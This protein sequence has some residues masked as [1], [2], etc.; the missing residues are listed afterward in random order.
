M[1]IQGSF[2]TG[3]VTKVL[4]L[5]YMRAG[6]TFLGEMLSQQQNAFLWFE[7]LDGV[8]GHLYSLLP[9]TKPI[10]MLLK[11]DFTPRYITFYVTVG[12]RPVAREKGYNNALKVINKV[13]IDKTN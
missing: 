8:F 10:D 1:K 11:N 13:L 12:N 7:P 3:Y 6:S 9:L 2:F 5:S 4:I